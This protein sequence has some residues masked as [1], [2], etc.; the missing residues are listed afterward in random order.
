M[1]CKQKISW[2]LHRLLPGEC[3]RSCLAL[4]RPAWTFAS[5]WTW[6]RGSRVEGAAD[7]THLG[8]SQRLYAI[9]HRADIVNCPAVPHQ[10][11]TPRHGARPHDPDDTRHILL[12]RGHR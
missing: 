1:R 5:A 8:M 3:R 4:R 11:V 7:G 9:L 12:L 10:M 6:P 2:T